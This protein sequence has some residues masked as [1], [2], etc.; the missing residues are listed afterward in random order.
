MESKDDDKFEKKSSREEKL[1]FQNDEISKPNGPRDP[2]KKPSSR[3]KN[4][5]DQAFSHIKPFKEP[6]CEEFMRK[7]KEK[8]IEDKLKKKKKKKTSIDPIAFKSTIDPYFDPAG[9]KRQ[10]HARKMAK[11]ITRGMKKN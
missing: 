7:K 11:K 9:S 8:E 6:N 2:I 1:S 10:L 4:K 3:K 5:Y